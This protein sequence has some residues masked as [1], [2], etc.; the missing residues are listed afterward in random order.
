[1]LA[2]INNAFEPWD[3]EEL[4]E[5]TRPLKASKA[6]WKRDKGVRKK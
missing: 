1:V 3:D 6:N 5:A 4:L 2:N